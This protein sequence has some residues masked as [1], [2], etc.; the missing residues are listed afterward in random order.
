MAAQRLL[1]AVNKEDL[2]LALARELQCFHYVRCCSTGTEAL[3]ILRTEKPD[4]LVLE[5]F[6]PEM[7]GLTVLETIASENIRPLVLALTNLRNDYLTDSAQRLGITYALLTPASLD[8]IVRRTL[9]LRRHLNALPPRPTRESLLTQ[10]LESITIDSGYHNFELL[11][12]CLLLAASS[13]DS[14]PCKALYRDTARHHRTTVGAVESGI[15]HILESAFS[16]PLWEPY[17]PG[18]HRR[19]T[20]KD[21]LLKL[22]QVLR[23]RWEDAGL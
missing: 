8:T 16:P 12:T 11:S 22:S 10:L 18:C 23:R 5:L 21:F 3:E 20:N 17:F 13:P 6:L 1:I 15:R 14:L 9:D 19:P 2:G 4:I 7:D